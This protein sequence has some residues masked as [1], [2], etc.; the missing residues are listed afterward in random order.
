VDLLN[1]YCD[2]GEVTKNAIFP[3]STLKK[4]H[5]SIAYH[6]TCEAVAAGT[7]CVTKEDGKTN[8]VA[9]VLLTKLLPQPTKYFLCD[10]FVY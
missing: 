4:K 3:K 5:N 8:L 2:N 7:I 6:G 1:I 10:Q 9:E